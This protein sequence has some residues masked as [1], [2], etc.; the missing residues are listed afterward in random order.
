MAVS[1]A[2]VLS[3]GCAATGPAAVKPSPSNEGVAHANYYA[4]LISPTLVPEPSPLPTTSSPAVQVLRPTVPPSRLS[5]V[6]AGLRGQHWTRL[7]T[8]TRVVALTFDAGSGA[9][10]IPSILDTLAA[11]KV[12]ATFFLTGRWVTV[13]P[14]LAR[15]I[16]AVPS[17]A[18]GNHTMSHPD[19]RGLS[20]AAIR[21]QLEDAE[22]W[23]DAVAGRAS[24]RPIFRFPYGAYD[25][26]TLGVVNDEG[27]A[28]VLWTVDTLGWKGASG[29]Q[30]ADSVYTRAVGAA[31][32]GEIVLMHVG[33]SPDGTM[34]D[35]EALPRVIDELRRR[36]YGFVNLR[37][38]LPG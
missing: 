32:P 21:G 10:G 23:L 38:F 29:G 26:R 28:S 5:A 15:R 25:A 9:Q 11:K 22:H 18:V 31:Q 36:G 19:L 1:L 14:E 7:P 8:S 16:A 3:A 2:A 24:T 13:Y 17:Y 20:D 37:E 30:S 6:P 33:A 27:F 4:P 34:L 35:A 12:P